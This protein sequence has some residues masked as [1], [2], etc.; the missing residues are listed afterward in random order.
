M[1]LDD[2]L[3]LL[4]AYL[5]IQQVRMGSRLRVVIDVPAELGD[6]SVPPFIIQPLAENAIRHG[7]EPLVAG[8]E[9]R[10]RARRKDDRLEIEISDT[11]PGMTATAVPGVG[12]ANV[13]ARLDALYHER[14]TLTLQLNDPHGLKV[15]VTIPLERTEGAK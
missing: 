7:L 11:G 10:V 12:L 1:T 6:L 9:L 3:T 15:K 2:E 8:G 13:R 4:R 5:G 14:A